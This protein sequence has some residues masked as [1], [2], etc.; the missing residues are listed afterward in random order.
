[1]ACHFVEKWKYQI[2]FSGINFKMFAVDFKHAKLLFW[3]LSSHWPLL[4][5]HIPWPSAGLN[6]RV[7]Q[8]SWGTLWAGNNGQYQQ[9]WVVQAKA[10]ETLVV[11]IR[12]KAL[13]L[14]L[15]LVLTQ[16]ELFVDRRQASLGASQI[17]MAVH[18]HMHTLCQALH[19]LSCNWHDIPTF[20]NPHLGSLF[21][22]HYTCFFL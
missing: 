12:A 19:I 14:L 9:R 7:Q 4:P 1:M 10:T 6:K 15:Q 3:F 2:S 5:L 17:Q 21:P 18:F 16:K 22:S 20:Y 11:I 8:W 13:T